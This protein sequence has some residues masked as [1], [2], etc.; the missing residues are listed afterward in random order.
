MKDC[1]I[2]LF[3][4]N[5]LLLLLLVSNRIVSRGF[6]IQME[7]LDKIKYIC[8]KGSDM[9]EYFPFFKSK[10]NRIFL[11]YNLPFFFEKYNGQKIFPDFLTY[12]Q[13]KYEN[14]SPC[15]DYLINLNDKLIVEEINKLKNGEKVDESTV[16]LVLFL[17][18]IMKNEGKKEEEI[19]NLTFLVMKILEWAGKMEEGN[20]RCSE[21]E[22]NLDIKDENSNLSRKDVYMKA[23]LDSIIIIINKYPEMEKNKMRKNRVI[24]KIILKI[25]DENLLSIKSLMKEENEKRK[26]EY[27]MF[28]SNG[29]EPLLKNHSPTDTSL[30][31]SLFTL[32]YMFMNIKFFL[33]DDD[34]KEFIKN[35]IINSIGEFLNVYVELIEVID[36]IEVT[37]KLEG[38]ES[39]EWN[40]EQLRI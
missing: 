27:F 11:Y 3:T 1:L 36:D 20:G 32:F 34:Y 5:L 26:K 15:Y 17:L 35:N 18:S 14:L 12:F 23:L 31:L 40:E 24:G 9:F 37:K 7:F 16:N 4:C 25:I 6:K 8:T 30:P 28:A 19:E 13:D 33:F 2:V 39:I 29:S 21:K 10:M 22:K 38:E